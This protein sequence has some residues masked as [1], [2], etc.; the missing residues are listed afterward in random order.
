MRLRMNSKKLVMSAACLA[1]ASVAVI[2]MASPAFADTGARSGDVVGVGSDT[3]QN[4]AD[5]IFDGAPG[6]SG[7]YNGIGN[8]NRVFNVDSTGDA[9]GRAVYDGTCGAVDASGQGQLCSATSNLAPN[10]LKGSVVLRAG[11]GP[12][13]RPNGSGAGVAALTSDANT[14]YG[15]LP[16]GSIQYAR[17]SRLPNASEESL[18]ASNTTCGGLHVYQVANDNLAI[19]RVSNGYNGVAALTAQQLVSIYTCSA[20]K[21]TDVGGTSTDTIHPLIPQSGSGTRNF[22][23]ADLQTANNGTAV[24][25]GTCVRTV[26]EHDPTGFYNDP[27]PGDVI[28]PFSTAKLALDNSGYFQNGAGYSGTVN[29]QS[30]ASGAYTPNYLTTLTG[31]GSYNSTRGLYFVIRQPDLGITTPFQ[32]GSAQNYA[33]ALFAGKAS[34]IA[35]SSSAPL[36][37][38]AGL[39]Q[40]YIDCGI[41]PTSC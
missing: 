32:A 2:S 27:T 5:F 33:Q 6:T 15:G 41:N 18:C 14:N 26:Q 40:A 39:T 23:L 38:A 7:A 3:V 36:L 17:M 22:F 10:L 37:A 8:N 34:F 11:T 29:G 30:L 4:A 19:A 20:T 35:R 28:E 9:N 24:N 16:T 25:P 13:V 1:G 21:W 31:S 12:V